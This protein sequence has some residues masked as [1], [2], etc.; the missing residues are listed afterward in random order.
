MSSIEET[1]QEGI[2]LTR[3]QERLFSLLGPL[4]SEITM[5]DELLEIAPELAPEMNAVRERISEACDH[6]RAATQVLQAKVEL[7]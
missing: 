6:F 5:I 3:A 2:R 7:L 1:V 4:E